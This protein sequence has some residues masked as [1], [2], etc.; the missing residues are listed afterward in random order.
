MSQVEIKGPPVRTR[1]RK[2]WVW[3]T[4]ALFIALGAIVTALW[5]WVNSHQ[6]EEMVRGR[7]VSLL[8]TGTGGRVEIRSFHW[9]LIDLEAEASGVV[10]H[11]LEDP[12]D[13]P[14]AE[15]E[16]LRVGISVLGFLSPRIRLRDF[17]V[18]KPEFHLIYY[19]NGSTN[20]HIHA[21]RRKRTSLS[22]TRCSISRRGML[23]SNREC[24]ISTTGRRRSILPTNICRWIS[25][26]T[27]YRLC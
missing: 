14:Y 4:A 18:L 15:V 10:I 16:S 11:G 20:S 3:N 22:L 19:P 8:E 24:S 12:A 1:R 23:R 26:P 2:R 5:F 21:F 6:F 9:R 25:R 27:I 13:A 17:E 7:I